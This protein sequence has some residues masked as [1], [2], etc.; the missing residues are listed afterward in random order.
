MELRRIDVAPVKASVSRTVVAPAD[1]M[2]SQM[3]DA[4]ATGLAAAMGVESRRAM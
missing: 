1:G 2:G 3:R 4:T